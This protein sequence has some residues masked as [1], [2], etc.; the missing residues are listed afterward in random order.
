[1][2][3]IEDL[4]PGRLRTQIERLP[5]PARDRAV[6]WLGNF[7]FTELDL[8]SLQ[9]DPAGGIFYADDFKLAPLAPAADDPDVAAAA[10]PVSPFP[11]SLRFHSRPGAA[12]VLFI[13]FSGENVSG[14]A[15]NTSLGR[16]TI[17]A[18]AFSTDADYTTFSDAEQLA[19]KQIWQ[20]MA[21]DY[22]PFNIDVTTERPATFTTRT[23]H[24]LITRNTDA[25]GLDNPAATSGGVAYVNVFGSASYASYRPAWIYFN[26]LAYDESYI[27][28]AAAHEIGHNMGLS[29][30]GRTD[31]Y[32]YYGG[33]GSGDTSWGPLMGTGYNRNVSQW[34]K[35]EYYLANNTQDDLAVIAGKTSYRADDHGNTSASATALMVSGGTNVLATTPEND[36]T[37]TNSANKGV[38]ERNTDVDVFSFAAGTGM[39]DLTVNPWNMPSSLTRGGNLDVAVELYNTNGTR[40]LTN[41]SSGQTFV[42][43]QTNLTEGIYYLHVR[44]SGSGNPTSSVPTGYTTYGSIGQY[45]ITGSVVTS[46]SVIPP[47]ATLQITDITQPGVGSKQ[48]TVTYSDNVAIDVTTLDS[49]DILVTG[50]NG[51]SRA[52]QLVSVNILSNGSPR[53]AT[54]SVNPPS[55]AF[56]TESD[57]GTYTVWMQTNQ[58]HDTEGAAVPAGQL[59]QFSVTVPRALY[60]AN[61]DGNPGWSLESQW[62]Y[63]KP[64]Y[65]SGTGPMNGFTGT[66]IIGYNLSG[67]YPN[68]LSTAYATT[69]VINCS[70]STTLTLRFRRWLGLKSAD[71]AVIQVSTNGTAWTDVWSSSSATADNSWQQVQYALPSWAA[72][73]PSV[74]LRWGLGSNPA[75][76]DIG[77]NID[78]VEILGDG[79]L[80]TTPPVP[81][82]SVANIVSAGSPTHSFTVT[83]TDD[84]AVSVASLSSSNLIVTGPNGYSNLVDYVGVD[85]PTDGTPRIAS[86]SAPAPGGIWDA[87]DN[88]S[89]QITIQNRQVTDTA[90]NAIAETVLGTFTV[91]MATNQQS[92]VVS[93]TLL[94]VPEGSNSVFTIRLAEQPLASVTVTVA[95]ASGDTNL[96]VA[97]GATNVFTSVNWSNPVSVVLAAL[98]DPDQTNGTAT[99]ECRSDGL[100]TVTVQAI[101]QDTTPNNLPPFVIITSPTNGTAL[102]A[103]AS[104]SLQ[105][106]SSDSD[107]TVNQVEFFQGATSLGVDTNILFS[108]FVNSLAAGNYSFSAVATDN[109]GAKATNTISLTVASNVAP[110]VSITSPTNNASFLAPTDLTFTA[111]AS[112]TD[113]TITK[114]EFFAGTNQL[115]EDLTSP[116]SL[117]WSNVAAGTYSLTARAT[118]DQ[119]TA[120]SSAVVMVAV[121]NTPANP[122]T[123]LNP[124]WVGTDFIFSFANQSGSTYHI[125]YKD[126]LDGSDWQLLLTNLVGNGS[127]LNVTNRNPSPA[128]RFYRVEAQ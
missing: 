28:E 10:V 113:G 110:T 36:P 99:F 50:T 1:M 57:G 81:L 118:D 115:G 65:A 98:P 40:L 90:N 11:A 82:I 70:G 7:H 25:N 74:R 80:D 17:P 93:P 67:N 4:P 75:Q 78:D 68:R 95:R 88:G 46:S 18:V 83:Y 60:F 103:P 12:N 125:Q 73:S 51:Y 66:N 97:S 13:N 56:W 69:P 85:T 53:V 44:N 61:M 47:G 86:Y 76:N 92:L 119:G 122:V 49:N 106:S 84:S 38:L 87:A 89:Y 37:N 91:A 45:F 34:S 33:H 41:N 127:I 55:G 108:M 20:R 117:V 27:A 63:G 21:E 19:I 64:L 30:D 120:T 32:E 121:T 43:V 14:T 35:G 107:G 54:Y 58:V 112:D 48:F 29:H 42:R 5:A 24:A 105:A 123:I 96:I 72:G 111:N 52:A 31:G 16:T 9:V 15:W 77:W 6:A 114:V 71:T 79:S 23:A 126:A 59:G 94:N 124:A 62:Q 39:I 8:N 104:F 116:Y 22:A 101:E 109:L 26:N 3:R 100:A 102:F 2:R 128:A